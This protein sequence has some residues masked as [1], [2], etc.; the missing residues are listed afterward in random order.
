MTIAV[1]CYLCW[2]GLP[3][4]IS[5]AAGAASNRDQSGLGRQRRRRVLSGG[6]QRIP[7]VFILFVQFPMSVVLALLFSPV[8]QTRMSVL[9]EHEPDAKTALSMG[10]WLLGALV[11]CGQR[12]VPVQSLHARS[13]KA[14]SAQ[15]AY[16][17]MSKTS[18]HDAILC[19]FVQYVES[20]GRRHTSN[21]LVR[22]LIHQ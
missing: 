1:N 13:L 9:T 22:T 8:V 7:A 21:M 12:F 4:L 19:Q 14:T 2:Q 16:V 3:H 5:F 11:T 17:Y 15:Q 6:S 20:T 10:F 18:S